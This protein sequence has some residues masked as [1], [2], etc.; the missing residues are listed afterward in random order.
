MRQHHAG[1]RYCTCVDDNPY[2]YSH[3]TGVTGVA[4][5]SGIPSPALSRCGPTQSWS[6]FRSIW[7]TIMPPNLSDAVNYIYQRAAEMGNPKINTSVERIRGFT[8]WHRSDIT[9]DRRHDLG[10]IRPR[11]GCRRRKCRQCIVPSRLWCC[12]RCSSPGLR[13]WV[14]ESWL[15]FQLWPTALIWQYAVPDHGRWSCCWTNIG[16]PYYNAERLR[17]VCHLSSPTDFTA[18]S[19]GGNAKTIFSISMENTWSNLPSHPT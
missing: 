4:A 5:S 1:K 17:L 15:Y 9:G 12:S 7:I 6:R 8:R 13:N 10:P 11:T 19:G 2:N 16:T 3:G 14:M 18:H